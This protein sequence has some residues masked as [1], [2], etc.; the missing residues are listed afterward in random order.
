M[1]WRCLMSQFKATNEV[2]FKF[3]LFERVPEPTGSKSEDAA[4]GG[5]TKGPLFAEAI[6]GKKV[7]ALCRTLDM[8]Y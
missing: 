6:Q 3:V 5:T 2:L 7:E 1:S 8:G 4:L